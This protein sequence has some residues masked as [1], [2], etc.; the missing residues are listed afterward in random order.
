MRGGKQL[1]PHFR[2]AWLIV[3][4]LMIKNE[5]TLYW[6]PYDFTIS[7]PIIT[8]LTETRDIT[9]LIDMV[10]SNRKMSLLIGKNT[11]FSF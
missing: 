5:I 4:F 7:L 2:R 6:N 9:F 11:D 3:D 10:H 1:L 8:M